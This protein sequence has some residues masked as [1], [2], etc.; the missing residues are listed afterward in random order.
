MNFTTISQIREC[1]ELIEQIL[2]SEERDAKFRVIMPLFCDCAH[3]GYTH[4]K[5]LNHTNLRQI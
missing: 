1:S 5:I 4:I 2:G 3:L